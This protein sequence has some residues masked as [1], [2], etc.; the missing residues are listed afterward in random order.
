MM[1][2]QA[3]PLTHIVQAWHWHAVTH[4][5]D[6]QPGRQEWSGRYDLISNLSEWSWGCGV[7]RLCWSTS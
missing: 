5:Y 3:S 6:L 1:H 4:K 2:S 7:T